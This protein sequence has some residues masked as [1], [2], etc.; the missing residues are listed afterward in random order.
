MICATVPSSNHSIRRESATEWST[1]ERATS[2]CSA[3]SSTFASS[4]NAMA[5]S[6]ALPFVT[7]E[8]G[9]WTLRE[10]R[11]SSEDD[12]EKEDAMRRRGDIRKC[13]RCDIDMAIG[14]SQRSSRWEGASLP[15]DLDEYCDACMLDFFTCEVSRPNENAVVRNQ[16][17][18]VSLRRERRTKVASS[19]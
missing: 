8:A 9:R 14:E 2:T 16:A 11:P 1:F 18:K 7:Q 19:G 10:G 17:L 15:L 6:L 13:S 12:G 4:G 3:I 5:A